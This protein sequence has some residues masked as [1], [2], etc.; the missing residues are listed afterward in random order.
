[1]A[2]RINDVV[3]HEDVAVLG[4]PAQRAQWQHI[5]ELEVSLLTQPQN[6]DTLLLRNKLKLIKGVLYWDM[7]E[8]YPSAFTSSA[9]NSRA[10]T[11]C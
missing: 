3:N 4:T 11:N 5:A 7:R 8:A 1:M 6:E 9:V 2:G 10:W